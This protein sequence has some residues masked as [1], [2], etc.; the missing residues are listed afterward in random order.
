MS[1]S[2]RTSLEASLGALTPA[3]VHG[4]SLK[5]DNWPLDLDTEAVAVDIQ[6]VVVVTAALLAGAGQVAN[7]AV[8]HVVVVAAA[9]A[10]ARA[11]LEKAGQV[12]TIVEQHDVVVT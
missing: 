2:A 10:A 6:R 7:F 5:A 9:L 12:E 4:V 1:I 11:G 3:V 8:Q